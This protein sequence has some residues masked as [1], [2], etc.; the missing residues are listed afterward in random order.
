MTKAEI[1]SNFIAFLA[2]GISI[3]GLYREKK[4]HEFDL[5]SELYKDFLILRLPTARDKVRITASG[6]ITGINEFINELNSLRKKSI[7]FK[8]TDFQFFEELRKK[9]WDLEDYLTM[10]EEPCTGEVRENFD[11]EVNMRLSNIYRCLLKK[12]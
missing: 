6:R 11:R 7:Y 2:L 12:F 4:N 3:Y 10:I 5:F 1:I 8:Y 9:L